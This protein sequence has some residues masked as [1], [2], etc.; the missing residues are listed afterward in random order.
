MTQPFV[1]SSA[2]AAHDPKDAKESMDKMEEF[3]A[4]DDVLTC[5]AHDDTL[6]G[7]VGLFA[8]TS[9][10]ARKEKGWRKEALWRF[11]GDYEEAVKETIQT[12]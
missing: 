4:R 3:D 9:A 7:I 10:T 11:L 12:T 2:N 5:T 6:L 1:L 8:D